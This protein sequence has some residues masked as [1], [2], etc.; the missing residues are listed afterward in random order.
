MQG[1]F[2]FQ[3]VN[4]TDV[5]KINLRL[6]YSKM[7]QSAHTPTNM[8]KETINI[9]IKCRT[10]IINL[11]FQNKSFPSILKFGEVCPIHKKNDDLNK[12]NY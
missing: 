6:N 8:F 4:E 5:M 3:K 12:E 1:K 10:R 2:S 9:H 7:T 11:S